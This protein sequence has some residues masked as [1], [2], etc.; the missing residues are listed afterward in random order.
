MVSVSNARLR[1][2]EKKGTDCDQAPIL[3]DA[4]TQ[5][6]DVSARGDGA[7][8]RRGSLA[9]AASDFAQDTAARRAVAGDVAKYA[10]DL[11]A[12]PYV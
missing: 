3:E 4:P 12:G 10:A 1:K 7:A 8:K 9:Q 11:S 5:S 2:D 6:R